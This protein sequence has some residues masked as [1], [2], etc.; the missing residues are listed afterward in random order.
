MCIISYLIKI[1][2]SESLFVQIHGVS[3]CNLEASF[4]DFVEKLI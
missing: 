3:I 1:H 4:W 2:L